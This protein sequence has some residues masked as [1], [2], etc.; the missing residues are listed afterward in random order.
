MSDHPCEPRWQKLIDRA[1]VG[2]LAPEKWKELS[3][4]LGT[5]ERCRAY[6]DR[7]RLIDEALTKSPLSNPMRDRIADQVLGA[8]SGAKRPRLSLS[9]ILSYATAATAVVVVAVLLPFVVREDEFT[10][11]GGESEWLG[12]PPGIA[13]F[14]I[15]PPSE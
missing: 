5:C 14:C 1:F 12:R 13:L 8:V 7:L 15:T 10:A 3:A 11:R 2:D 9:V 4:H 6:H